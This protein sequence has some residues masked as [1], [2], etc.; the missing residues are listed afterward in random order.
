[1]IFLSNFVDLSKINAHPIT[2]YY[3]LRNK[4][5]WMF[6]TNYYLSNMNGRYYR[7]FWM[8]FVGHAILL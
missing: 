8:L 3:P 6:I 2:N 7:L 5:V 4:L 1:M